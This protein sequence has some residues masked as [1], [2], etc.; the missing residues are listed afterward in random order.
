MTFNSYTPLLFCTQLYHH[1]IHHHK[2][3]VFTPNLHPFAFTCSFKMTYST[4]LNHHWC[5]PMML[6]VTNPSICFA[7]ANRYQCE[8]NFL[9]QLSCLELKRKLQKIMKYL[10]FFLWRLCWKD[11]HNGLNLCKVSR[12]CKKALSF[13]TLLFRL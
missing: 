6:E 9:Q 1:V 5:S 2:S 8:L 7:H 4:L 11:Q 3:T 13:G 12:A 10:F